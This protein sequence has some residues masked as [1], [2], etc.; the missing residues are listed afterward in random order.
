M[1]SAPCWESKLPVG[2]LG[3]NDLG[4]MHD[5]SRNRHTLLP[6]PES[7]LGR[8]CRRAVIETNSST[9]STSGLDRCPSLPAQQQRKRDILRCRQPGNLNGM[10]GR[11]SRL[12]P[13]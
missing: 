6:P 8:W 9:S 1:I 11:Q 3:E 7:S 10:L 12:F 2:S 5:R 13:A 4:L